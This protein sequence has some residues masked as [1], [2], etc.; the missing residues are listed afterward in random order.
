[1]RVGY[2]YRNPDGTVDAYFDA[3]IVGHRFR[4]RELEANET[5]V[6]A[7]SGAPS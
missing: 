7:K 1:M 2:A 5:I 3:I 6:A 4:L